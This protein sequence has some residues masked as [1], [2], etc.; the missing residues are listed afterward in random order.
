MPS[1]PQ[2]TATA[3]VIGKPDNIAPY[4]YWRDPRKTG[5]GWALDFKRRNKNRTSGFDYLYLGYWS[6]EKLSTMY[7]ALGSSEAVAAQ[8]RAEIAFN[9]RKYLARK[10]R[11]N[12]TN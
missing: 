12:G 5:K 11:R 2:S 8:I 3:T 1:S 9:A 4:T 7:A 10:A 6:N